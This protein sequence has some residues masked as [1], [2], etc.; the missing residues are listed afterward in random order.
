LKFSNQLAK[1]PKLKLMGTCG[2]W[3]VTPKDYLIPWNIIKNK[4]KKK[5]FLYRINKLRY[6][7]YELQ[8]KTKYE[9]QIAKFPNYHIRTN[10][11][12]IDRN[13]YIKYINVKSIP[14]YKM[15]TFCVESGKY[16][17]TNFILNNK[18]NIGVL[19]QDEILYKKEDWDKSRTF[20][21]PDTSNIIIKDKFDDYYKNL[22]TI[23]KSLTE[24]GVWRK[25]LTKAD[26]QNIKFSVLIPTKNRLELLKFAIN[27]VLKQ[28]YSNWEIIISDNC[29]DED[30]KS[31]IDSINN[32]K[33]KYMRQDTPISV[34][35]NWNVANN[36]ACG[37]Y[38]IM[39]GDD[40]ALLP[41][42]FEKCIQYIQ[43]YNC[44]ELLNFGAY[45]YMQP[46]VSP[47]FPNGDLYD[48]TKNSE[49]MNKKTEPFCPS[50][51]ERLHLIQ[52]SLN[53]E[54]KFGFNMQFFLYSRTLFVKLLKYGNFYE[55]P[56]PDYYT[57]NML[58]AVASEVVVIPENFLVIGIT[59]KS[60]G[61]YYQNNKEKEGMAFHKEADYRKYA[62]KHIK[63]KL[64]NIAEMQTAAMATFALIP[65]R[66]KQHNLK[67]NLDAY[68]NA[69]INRITNDYPY[70]EA[71]AILKKELLT[72]VGI[73]KY[74]KYKKKIR[75]ISKYEFGKNIQINNKKSLAN[76]DEAIDSILQG[77]LG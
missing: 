28:T 15:D 18:Y 50:I 39:L 30:I 33:I 63:N 8:Q 52:S 68:Y 9:S 1:N 45:I 10:A 19:G 25:Y 56:Y 3:D 49:Y 32:N 5:G 47:M 16:S 76:I 55:P 37:D 58:M 64:C 20:F 65:K 75:K 38:T 61:Y 11:F 41:D 26:P 35:T 29:S 59:P 4:Y 73:F 31:Y 44:P 77:N 48:S 74:L 40:D 67:L 69:V 53:F 22:T 62:P 51:E 27:S 13:M 57:A 12:I 36:V 43:K 60:Y 24:F 21:S 72:K 23:D 17:L 14:K 6:K 7:L 42:F 70:E 66:L 2:S 54:Y 34:T 71:I 46:N